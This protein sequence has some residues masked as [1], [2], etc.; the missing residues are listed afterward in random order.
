MKKIFFIVLIGLCSC[1]N[2]KQYSLDFDEIKSFNLSVSHQPHSLNLRMSG[3]SS[4]EWGLI[5]EGAD[6]TH[7]KEVL[8]PSGKLDTV[9]RTDWY[10]KSLA[11][12]L[13]PEKGNQSG[14]I[15]IDVS[16]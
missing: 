3:A 7:Y 6:N 11:C 15:N 2:S 5:L 14:K 12:S 10:S 9:I 13:R 16:L 4:D 8:F 1:E